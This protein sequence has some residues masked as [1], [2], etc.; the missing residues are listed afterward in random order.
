MLS[1]G[2]F[3]TV[4]CGFEYIM[5]KRHAVDEMENTRHLSL[6]HLSINPSVT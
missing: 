3:V 2:S 6:C 4:F 1:G 5:Q